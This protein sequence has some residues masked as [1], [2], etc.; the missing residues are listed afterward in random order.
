MKS[1]VR[2]L[3]IFFCVILI[4]G[5]G[6]FYYVWQQSF[7]LPGR[8][9]NSVREYARSFHDIDFDAGDLNINFPEHTILAKKLKVM[10]PG[11]KPFMEADEATIFLASGTGPLDLYFSRAVIEKIELGNLIIDA[12]APRPENAS[13]DAR[14]LAIPAREVF[15]KGLTLNTSVS[16]FNVP[17]FKAG[18]IRTRNNASVEMSFAKGPLGGT[19]KL[20]AMLG[21]NTGEAIINFHWHERDFSS[22]IPLIFLSHRFGLNITSGGAEINLNY[23]GNLARRI[24][25]PTANLARLLNYELK[26]SVQVSSST[27]NWAG[28]QGNID[29]ELN[30]EHATPWRCR[31]DAGLEDGAV[32]LQGVW[33]GNAE[34][35]TDFS[36]IISCRNLRLNKKMFD[37]TGINLLNTEPGVI[38]FNGRFRGN[39][40][41]ISGSGSAEASEWLYQNKKINRAM[42]DWTLD[43]K[44]SLSMQGSLETEIGNL[45]AS[46]TIQVS[47]R[48]KGQGSIAGELHKIDLQK[49]KPFIEVPFSGRCNGPFAVSFNLKNPASTTYDI[50]LK[51]EEGNFYNIRPK[52][53]SA[54]I[55][56]TGKTWNLENPVA[57]FADKSSISVLGLITSDKLDAEVRVE[58][59]DLAV[60]SVP[61]SIA[62]G[63]VSLQAK[64]GGP[65]QQPEVKGNLISEKLSLM[66]NSI[67][68]FRAQ[69]DIKG[70]LLTLS[71]LV[72]KQSEKGMLDGFLSIDILTGRIKGLRLSF[73]RLPIGIL[74]KLLPAGLAEKTSA[75][76]F[77]GYISFGRENSRNVW[78]YQL[79]GHKLVVAEE[80]I[81]S[82]YL[83]GISADR[84]TD[85]KSFFV[86]AFGGSINLSGL[87][88]DREHFNGSLEI[89]SLRLDRIAEIR[90]QFPGLTGEMNAQG[91][92]EWDGAK[93]RGSFTIF[94]K[95][96][97][98][99]KR[100]LGNFGGE[101][102]VDDD[103]L[104]IENGEFD[105]LGLK[106][107]G[108]MSWYDRKPYSASIEFNEADLTF[109]Q[110]VFGG[111]ALDYGDLQTTGKCQIQGDLV[112][113]TPDVVNLNLSALR[114]QKNNDVIIANRPLQILYQNNGFEV[115]SLELKYRQG[116]L[117]VE[118]VFTPE[119]NVALMIN[120]RN[121]SVKAI[122]NFFDL[123]NWNYDGSLS[124]EAR[125][126]GD[127]AAARLKGSARIEDFV[128]AGRR[129][130]E[131]RAG[132]DG[133]RSGFDITDAQVKLTS[134]SFNLNG[135]VDLD[136]EFAPA[137]I[138]M[139]LFIPPG[140]ISDLAVYVPELFREASGTVKADLMLTGRPANPEIAGDLHLTADQLAFSNM[141]KP[142]TNVNFQIS[143]DDRVINIDKLEANLGRGKLSG[144]GQV[145]FRDT[146]G[147]ITANISGQK[148]DLSFMN[149]ELSNASA[150][151]AITGD[152]YNPVLAG[153]VFVPRGKFNLTSDILGKRKPV[154]FF[155]DTL[156][157]RF[158]FEIPRNFWVKSSFLNSEM[159]GK[160]SIFGDL[161]HINLDGGVSCVQG[162]LYFKQRPFV[163][164]TGEINF[165]GVDNGLDPHIYVK[166]EGQIQSTKIF[167]TLNGRVSSFT[168]Q[169]YSTPPMSEGEILALLTLGRDLNT[170][171]R[172]DT[173]ELFETEILEGL[174]NSYISALIGNT[175]STALNLDELF[176]SSLFD[177]TSGKSRPYIRVGKYI[178][179]NIF[180][181]Y[182]GSMEQGQE[183]AYI[184]EYRLPKG[185]VVNVE[186]KEPEKEQQIGVRYDWKFW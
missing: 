146:T 24:K 9:V 60:F 113:R 108:D 22:F 36:G 4:A 35:M 174:K 168:P 180:M 107:S 100:D 102:S 63:V 31:I 120:G 140:P 6:A 21:V 72:V 51:M 87:M 165:G 88:N 56:G 121:F 132:V 169:I 85:L 83:E 73:Q 33:E 130:P 54:R 53:L 103:G 151:V 64:V 48:T 93:R 119:K 57:R 177:R 30:K 158:D 137:N 52:E 42:F 15:V 70:P 82:I 7:K 28:I 55:Y 46:S 98:V 91:A 153:K 11:E 148:L 149:L 16:V 175:I 123:P 29:L 77:G 76:E 136:Q 41:V 147:S 74:Q 185:F 133:D 125:L 80:K 5:A 14:L 2:K 13:G 45:T 43:K 160:F 162:K 128:V 118:G 161:D 59:V 170:A 37:L 92:L 12:T 99:N 111:R 17:D 40:N 172:S 39:R 186:F 8:L 178:G 105:K 183:E 104:V 26:G 19:S 129:I 69:I 181:A 159:R 32:N 145:D 78:N 116:V 154:D 68:S 114:I 182:E 95:D 135:R 124:V 27:F 112:S 96:I 20:S 184:F 58:K 126:F 138:N 18:F 90:R 127:I 131:V 86:K 25:K 89:E 67:D 144:T 171:M 176:L 62:T 79:E 49:L 173:R 156:N 166:S 44:A 155:F 101:I 3:F 134:S 150:A 34:Q 142:L 1:R 163:I 141:R 10:L 94:T 167:L 179:R 109:L 81:D 117:G 106:I 75:G 23:R 164:E 61:E 157:Y 97:H 152:L 65:L 110:E 50:N 143:T 115:R 71:P 66:R 47:G 122:G 139:H 84:Q 38:D